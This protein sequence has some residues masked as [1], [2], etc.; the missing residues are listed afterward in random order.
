MFHLD[1]GKSTLDL[2]GEE[3]AERQKEIRLRTAQ[4]AAVARGLQALV[5][6]E[7]SHITEPSKG[8]YHE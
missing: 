3:E 4:L 7:S 1:I 8:E 5:T 6:K 2:W